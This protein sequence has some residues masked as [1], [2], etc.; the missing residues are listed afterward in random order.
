MA[1]SELM[2]K[3]AE[4]A[5]VQHDFLLKTAA[6]ISLSPFRDEIVGELDYIIKH[7]NSMLAAAGQKGMGALKAVGGAMG[8]TMPYVGMGLVASVAASLAGDLYDAAHRGLTKSR[9][10][11]AMLEANPDLRKADPVAIQAHFNTLHRFNPEFSKDPNVAATYVRSQ[12]Q[13]PEGDIGSVQNLVSS[14]KAIRDARGMR[15][16]GGIPWQLPPTGAEQDQSTAQLALTKAQIGK[17][18][19]EGQIARQQ[20]QGQGIESRPRKR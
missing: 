7:A 10:F 8:K 12:A 3:V 17:T 13:F 15:P 16:V 4:V 11:K 1:T 2:Q 14:R 5:P 6:E 19:A 20:A 18:T 9:N